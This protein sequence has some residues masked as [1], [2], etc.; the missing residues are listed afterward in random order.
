MTLFSKDHLHIEL[1]VFEKDA[2][3]IHKGQKVEVTIPDMAGKVLEAE[4]FVVGQSINNDRQINV[5]AH[6]PNEEE[7]A[8]LVPGM[9]LEA[10]VLLDPMDSWVV[11]STAVVVSEGKSYV[12]VQR[13]N[14]EAGYKLEKVEVETGMESEGMI[15]LMPNDR[16]DE[17]TVILTHGGFNLL[18]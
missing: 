2:A 17:K 7:E 4:V 1:V 8:F 14:A 15:V 16:L 12:L 9:F 6:L 11:P 3:R 5:H 18:P 10:K 13:E